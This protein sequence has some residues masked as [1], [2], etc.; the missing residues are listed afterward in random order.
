MFG[1]SLGEILFLSVLALIVIG[2]DDLPKVAQKIGR[3]IN[4][5]KRHTSG[6]KNQITKEINKNDKDS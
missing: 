6:W 2:P 4:E 1:F 3:F 5:I